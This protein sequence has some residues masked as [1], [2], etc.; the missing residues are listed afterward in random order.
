MNNTFRKLIPL[1]VIAAL[2][3]AALPMQSVAAAGLTQDSRPPA[4]RGSRI[5]ERKFKAEQRRYDGQFK[6]FDKSSELL[7]KAQGLIDRAEENGLDTSA[8]QTALY[9]FEKA[10]ATVKPL[11]AQAG[12]LID[13][14]EGFDTEGKVT[15]VE[16]AAETVEKIHKLLDQVRDG[17]HDEREALQHS[18]WDLF[19]EGLK[20][21]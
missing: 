2:I 8:A 13:A 1:L 4:G 10:I 15:D 21:K 14:H 3:L 12:D 18:L 11:H 5:V 9:N 16:V 19:Q 6:A 7:E 20:K 17:V